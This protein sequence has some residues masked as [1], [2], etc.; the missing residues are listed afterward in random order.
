MSDMIGAVRIRG[1]VKVSQKVSRTM[2]DLKLRKK[3]QC[4]VFE[5]SEAVRGMMNAAKD[6]I[7]YGELDDE[8]LEKLEERKGSE[9]ESGDTVNLS[10]PS[11]GFKNTKTNYGQ[12]GS[13]GKR[14]DFSDLVDRMV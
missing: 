4:V 14:D 1:D 8:T 9:I 5:D 3:N 13:L 12:G 6:Y 2:N 7:A 10:P 11:K